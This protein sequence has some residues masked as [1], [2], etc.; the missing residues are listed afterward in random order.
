M[1]SHL[2]HDFRMARNF[3]KGAIGDA[4]NLFMAAAAFSF[5]MS[6]GAEGMAVL[7]VDEYVEVSTPSQG[8]LVEGVA[9]EVQQDTP[10]RLRAAIR[11]AMMGVMEPSG[12]GFWDSC[13]GAC[14]SAVLR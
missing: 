12:S 13:D 11:L 10:A 6:I 7:E 3:L 2:K 9:L 5:R 8:S 4:V 1:I 14:V